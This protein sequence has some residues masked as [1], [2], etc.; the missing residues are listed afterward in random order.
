MPVCRDS[1]IYFK[2]LSDYPRISDREMRCLIGFTEYEEAAE[3]LNAAKD[4][5]DYFDYIMFAWGNCQ[6]GDR[7]VMERALGRFPNEEDLST[8][9]RPG[10]RFYFLYD[11]LKDH[12]YRVFDGVLPLKIRGEL[13]LA[14][15]VYRIVIPAADR[16][17]RE[18]HIPAEL[19]DRVLYVENNTAD[20]WEWSGKIYR[21]IDA[22]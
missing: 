1:G 17:A 9:F 21:I 12:P 10:I 19:K 8:G 13:I 11:R 2:K 14:D 3:P 18:P 22:Q 7:L 5:Q 15:W 4:P 20:I 16:S 6:A